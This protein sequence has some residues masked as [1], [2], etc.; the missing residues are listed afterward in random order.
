MSRSPT[1]PPRGERGAVLIVVLILLLI[2]TVLGLASL[3]GTLMEE[4]MSAY[5]YD[6]SLSFQSA[7][8]ALRAA[9]DAIRGAAS[10]DDVGHDCTLAG[11]CPVIACNAFQAV[12]GCA[13]PWT[14]ATGVTLDEDLIAGPPQ[15][16]I[17]FMGRQEGLGDGGGLDGG[18]PAPTPSSRAYYRVTARSH[19]P[20]GS[21]RALT[22]LQSNVVRE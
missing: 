19:D 11:P 5:L 4:R 7:E 13:V 15:Y 16:Y 2:M 20:A 8:A 6:R 1:H 21:G 10:P 9:E 18:Y 22:V 3:R 17:E 14:N 12:D